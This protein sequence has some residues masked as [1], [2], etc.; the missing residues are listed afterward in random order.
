MTEGVQLEPQDR[1]VALEERAISRV[2]AFSD[3]VFAFAVTLLVLGIRIPLH[4]DADASAGLKSLLLRQWPS[5]VA[6]V[7][8]FANVGIVWANHRLAFGHLV[9]S[10]SVLVS[11]N[12]LELM[13]VAFLPV[14]TAVLGEW[15]ASDTNR[16]AAVVFYGCT[17]VLL[18]I[19][20]NLLWWYA[21][22]W[23][24]LTSP[25]LPKHKRRALTLAWVGGP[26][27]Y[28]VC[29]ALAL[30]DPRLS[31]VGFA[32][33]AILYLLPTPRVIMLA[34]RARAVRRSK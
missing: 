5:Y 15:A 33:L 11:L 22:Y 23:G 6:F 27:L 26:V 3:G 7:L 31:I 1:M 34:Q 30:V 16:L 29:V 18:G 20:H 2:E 12:L 24:C 17:F 21:A 8:T 9:R 19:S 14:P 25:E 32:C 4:T 28:A 13:V 10:D